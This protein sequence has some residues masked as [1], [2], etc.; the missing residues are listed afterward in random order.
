MTEEGGATDIYPRVDS[1]KPALPQENGM[2]SYPSFR[3]FSKIST[4]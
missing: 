2:C 1:H 4:Y 3:H